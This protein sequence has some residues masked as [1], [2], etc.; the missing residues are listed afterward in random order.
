MHT[1][2]TSFFNRYNTWLY[3][4]LV[5]YMQQ[6]KKVVKNDT[7]KASEMMSYTLFLLFVVS[8]KEIE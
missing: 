2:L 6:K 7:D 4:I 3:K 1:L 5:K 8:N